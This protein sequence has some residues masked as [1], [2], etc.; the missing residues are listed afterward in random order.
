MGKTLNMSN[1][2]YFDGCKFY[3]IIYKSQ[4]ALVIRLEVKGLYTTGRENN[5]R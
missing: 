5:P 1:K 2:M 3:I 4:Q